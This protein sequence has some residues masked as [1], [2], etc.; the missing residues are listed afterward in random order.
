MNFC[1]Y[2]PYLL[3]DLDEIWYKGP[4]HYE[5]CGNHHRG[6]RT[7]LTDVSEITDHFFTRVQL[8]FES[9][10]RLGIFSVPRHGVHHLLS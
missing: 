7:F 3:P 4:A 6:R 5:F 2:L 9:K 10:E 8:N 1:S